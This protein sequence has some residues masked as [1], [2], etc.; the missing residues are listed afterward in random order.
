MVKEAAMAISSYSSIPNRV[1]YF[2]NLKGPSI[3]VDTACSSSTVAI[4]MACESLIKG[5]CRIAIAGG[6]NLSIHPKKYLGLSLAKLTAGSLKSRSF[7]DG[8]GFIRGKVS[9]LCF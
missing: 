4:H 5:E 3:A 6:V 7:G 2:L 8:D 9:E 1:S